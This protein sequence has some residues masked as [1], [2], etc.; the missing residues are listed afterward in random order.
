MKRLSADSAVQCVHGS[1]GYESWCSGKL[2]TVGW[3]RAIRRR[4]DCGIRSEHSNKNLQLLLGMKSDTVNE[5]LYRLLGIN[6]DDIPKRI[7][8]GELGKTGMVG[9]KMNCMTCF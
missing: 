2:S 7:L 6:A 1:C 8:F 9:P 3:T 4:C 5:E